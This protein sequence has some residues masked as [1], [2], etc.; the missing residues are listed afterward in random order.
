MKHKSLIAQT[1]THPLFYIILVSIIPTLPLFLTGLLIHTHD[2]LVHL[3][4]LAEFYKA[5]SDGQFPVRWAGDLNY[6]YGLPLF[7]FIYHLPY[8]VGSLFLF[9]GAGLVVAFKL[10]LA[11]SFILSGIFMYIFAKIFF[12]DTNKALLVTIL[13]QFAPFR[14]VELLVRGSY[15]EVYTYAFLPLV[16][17][18]IFLTIKKPSAFSAGIISLASALLIISHN[19]VSL[20]F[21]GVSAFFV[22]IF[23][24]TFKKIALCAFGMVLGLITAAYYWVPALLEHKYTY[25]DLYMQDLYRSH[26]VP[27]QNFFIPNLFNSKSLDIG[28]VNIH[29]GI[30]HTLAIILALGSLIQYRFSNKQ[31]KRIYLFSFTILIASFF[32]MTE[33]SRPI[34]DSG[35]NLIRQF[36]FPWRFLSLVV[37][38]SSLLG[39]TF[40]Q[41]PAFRQKTTIIGLIFFIILTVSFYFKA[42]EGYDRVNESVYWD[43]ALNTTYYGE[44]DIVWSDGLQKEYPKN[45]VDFIAG[46]G[47]V[48]DYTRKSNI[49]EYTVFANSDSTIVD[50]THYFPGWRVFVDGKKTPIEFQDQN[51]RGQLTFKIPQGSHSVIAV[52][53]ESKTRLLS[54]IF[55]IVGL[56]ITMLLFLTLPIKHFN[57]K[58]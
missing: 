47:K 18:G 54:D 16:L 24:R 11:L 5:L 57:E 38:A 52:F 20:L 7:N 10:S 21:F 23:A 30:F 4:R 48:Q 56:L 40:F 12:E 13:Y 17:Y 15:G 49:R 50:H 22:L 27:F 14:I 1:I 53:Q 26:F 8:Y 42:Q 44:T 43:F 28:A 36:Q 33:I 35:F 45:P 41:I 39:F 6:H 2:G 37:F 25:G 34:W 51:Y 9:L 29:I 3:P 46:D 19:S 58:K 32:F 31:D 55:S